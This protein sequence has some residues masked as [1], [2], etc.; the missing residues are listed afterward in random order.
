MKKLQIAFKGC[1]VLAV[2]CFVL[3]GAEAWAAEDLSNKEVGFMDVFEDIPKVVDI[4]SGKVRFL[5]GKTLYARE[6][7]YNKSKRLVVLYDESWHDGPGRIDLLRRSDKRLIKI[8]DERTTGFNLYRP[9]FDPAGQYVYALNTEKGIFRYSLTKR[10][11]EKVNIVGMNG[12]EPQVISFSRSGTKAVLSH[13]RYKGFL[14][15]EV[16]DNGLR[17]DREILSDFEECISAQW[18]GDHTIVFG[19]GKAPAA[20]LTLWKLDLNT[21]ELTQLLPSSMVGGD[22]VSL[23]ADEKAVVFTGRTEQQ[24]G[25]CL[26]LLRLD[27]SLPVQITKCSGGVVSNNSVWLD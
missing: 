10:K 1:V 5:A 7:D 26:W 19:G 16:T 2:A 13:G 17:I 4:Q 9:K 25:W 8:F 11:W 3:V 24:H 6:F 14:I 18:V 22:H 23:S 12:V 15:A 21:N 20:T 27:G